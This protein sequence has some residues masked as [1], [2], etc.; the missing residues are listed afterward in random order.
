MDKRRD[1]MIETN[2]ETLYAWLYSQQ[3]TCPLI[4]MSH[5]FSALMV[6]GLEDY[7]LKFASAGFAVLVYDHRNYPFFNN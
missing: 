7:A 3:E 5:G 6:M 4:I 2:G 1:I